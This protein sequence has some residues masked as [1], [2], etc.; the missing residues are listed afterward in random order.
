M[1]KKKQKCWLNSIFKFVGHLHKI[2][3]NKQK[4]L[5]GFSW[6]QLD[7][8]IL[9]VRRTHIF[10]S[11]ASPMDNQISHISDQ[12]S[13]QSKIKKHVEGV[14]NHFSC[15]LC[16]QVSISNSGQSG[17]RPIHRR[18]ITD[19]Q[20]FLM[21]IRHR[22]PNPCLIGIMIPISKKIIEAPSTMHSKKRH[23]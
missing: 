3:H 7:L 4:K 8:H 12:I 21:E 14:K 1:E 13:C 17:D 15:V 20:A 6:I 18:H 10:S 5:I 11:T 2:R 19:P 16:M 23:L 22:T 9:P